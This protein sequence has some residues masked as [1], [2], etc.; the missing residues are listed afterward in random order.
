MILDH[1][2]PSPLHPP[3]A[4]LDVALVRRVAAGDRE[5][6]RMLF[7]RFGREILAYL[8]GRL[9]DRGAAED[10]VQEIMLD[11]WR[12]S[13]ARFRGESRVRTWLL[14]IA[15][16]RACN[17]LRRRSR[18]AVAEDPVALAMTSGTSRG[19]QPG[20]PWRSEELI[21][22]DQAI[23][24]LPDA[25]RAA[26]ELVFYHG[27]SID[28]TAAVLDCAPGTIKS[29]LSRA[30]AELRHVLKESAADV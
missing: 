16:H 24:G 11:L 29:R 19:G 22:L 14:A 28:E 27:L 10:L 9:G 7:E 21:D 8:V 1:A 12:H 26:L 13:A 30:K 25:Q 3:A 6:H 4:D 17:E 23:L 2:M 18:L 5:A 15:H 20:G